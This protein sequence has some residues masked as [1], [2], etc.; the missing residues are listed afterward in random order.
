MN[1][2]TETYEQIAGHMT[3]K[4][5]GHTHRA[6]L[7]LWAALAAVVD[8]RN[9]EHSHVECDEQV[10]T[11]GVWWLGGGMLAHAQA[12]WG[13]DAE[14]L[15]DLWTFERA[16]RLL[17]DHRDHD[18]D[19]GSVATAEARP[20]RSVVGLCSSDASATFARMGRDEEAHWTA[21]RE[22]LFSDG[23]R[24]PLPRYAG[25]AAPTSDTAQ[26]LVEAVQQSMRS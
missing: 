24:M 16:I 9:V 23:A 8:V 11:W 21:S 10:T 22:L 12:S 2:F 5:S 26:T 18:P 13:T 20:L 7:P 1:G 14:P 19:R 4:T 25:G 17:N 6:P 15:R 3:H